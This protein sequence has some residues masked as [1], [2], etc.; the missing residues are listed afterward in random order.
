MKLRNFMF[1]RA[2]RV[3]CREGGASSVSVAVVR[4]EDYSGRLPKV[5]LHEGNVP[6]LNDLALSDGELEH[7]ATVDGRVEFVPRRGVKVAGV[8]RLDLLAR[9]SEALRGVSGSRDLLQDSSVLRIGDIDLLYC[10]M[11]IR[12]VGGESN[13]K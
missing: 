11:C 6:S 9:D 5:H 2:P 1:V 12:G 4:L 7:L 3:P 13:P 10:C 8:V